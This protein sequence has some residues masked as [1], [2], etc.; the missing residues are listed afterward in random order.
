MKNRLP[1]VLS[2]TALVV[3]VF[4]ITPLGHATSNIAQTHFAKSA[5]FLR[6]KAPSVAAKPNTIVQ[7]NG[8]G[9]IVG[10]P[11]ARGAQGAAGAP[12]PAGPAGPGGPAGPPGATGPPGAPN[13]NADALNGYAANQL[14]RATTVTNSTVNDN[15][16]TCAFTTLL[17]RAVAAPTGGILLVWGAI[18]AVRD[19]DGGTGV[20]ATLEGRVAVDATVASTSNSVYLE[21][22]GSTESSLSVSGAVPV[23]AGTRNVHLQAQECSSGIAYV[24]DKSLTTLF[25]P[26]GNAGTPG[27]LGIVDSSTSAPAASNNR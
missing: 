20:A 12:G 17:T 18:D 27:V 14:V 10:I 15:F 21:N 23:A 19:I 26:F 5:N 13:P 3:A 7:R 9:Q 16:N 4:G 25:V 24:G 8:K 1:I 11:V 6:G 2:T 22:Q